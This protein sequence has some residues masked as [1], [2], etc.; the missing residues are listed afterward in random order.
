MKVPPSEIRSALVR[1]VKLLSFYAELLNRED[2]GDRPTF[3]GTD[4]WLA[5]LRSYDGQLLLAEQAAAD[6]EVEAAAPLL[7]EQSVNGQP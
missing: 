7:L 5:F 1:A 3:A 6:A 2:G 4:E